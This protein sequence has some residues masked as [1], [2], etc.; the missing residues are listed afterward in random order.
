MIKS[1]V[2]CGFGHIYWRNAQRYTNAD[3]KISLYAG[4]PEQGVGGG[5]EGAFSVDVPIFA[6][7]PFKCSLFEIC[8]QE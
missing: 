4:P 1:A 7:E 6:D 2:S 5:A 3:L 8:N